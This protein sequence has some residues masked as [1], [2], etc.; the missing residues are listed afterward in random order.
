M[1]EKHSEMDSIKLAFVRSN[2]QMDWV[3]LEWGW[4]SKSG[5]LIQWYQ[6]FSSLLSILNYTG[7]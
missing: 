5:N 4:T 1:K 7:T 2:W 3:I 6:S